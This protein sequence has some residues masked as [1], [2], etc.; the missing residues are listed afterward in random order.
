MYDQLI[1][2]SPDL[3]PA[4]GLATSWETQDDG[5]TW[6]FHLRPGV[7]WQDGTPFTAEDARFQLQ[8]IFDSH[9]PAYQGPQAPDGND[10]TDRRAPAAPTARPTTR[11]RCSTPTSTSTAASRTRASRPSRR[12]TT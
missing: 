11:C 5:L 4:P 3:E 2:L 7:T 12:P 1:E 9:D 10:L 8:Y 6:M